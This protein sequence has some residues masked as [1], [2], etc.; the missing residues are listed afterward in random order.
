[1]KY[2]SF[3]NKN[4]VI[5][6]C[7]PS[8]GIVSE[9]YISRLDNAIKTLNKLGHKIVLSK[10]VRQQEKL[11]SARPQVRAEEFMDL[12]FDDNIDAV[13]S[14]AG[15]EFMMEILPYID[16]EKIKNSRPK[17]FQG[18]SDN[19]N[20]TFTITTLCDI[21]T[22]Y[23]FSFPEFG[24]SPWHKTI[25]NG[26]K[27]LR[28]ESFVV[29]N[30]TKYE[31]ESLKDLPDMYLAPYNCTVNGSWKILSAD[32]QV[33]ICGRLLGGC[34][35]ILTM[36]CG[37]RFDKVKE[38]VEKYKDDGIIWFLESCDLNIPAQARA[39]WQLKNAGWFKYAKGFIIGRPKDTFEV[40][41]IDYKQ[42]NY[43]HLKDLNVP[44]IIDADFGHVKPTACILN[45][46]YAKVTLKNNKG[47]IEYILKNRK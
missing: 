29:T 34:T 20:L 43:E 8:R 6:V 31:I 10:S 28:G 13:M 5:G 11:T 38:F 9:P 16:F 19:T 25:T 33:D 30:E 4:S 21:A 7:A 2:P 36:L 1:M 35:D 42:A 18:L 3:L 40:E 24:M 45:G 17:F 39:I 12:W 46:A 22:I 26:Y 37:T 41:G 27:L 44:V 15:G 23:G 14:C 47:K 32:R